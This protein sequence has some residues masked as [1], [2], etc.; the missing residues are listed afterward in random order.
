MKKELKLLLTNCLKAV[1]FFFLPFKDMM[2]LVKISIIILAVLFT[3]HTVPDMID[4]I[5]TYFYFRN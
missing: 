2:K 3:C 5:Q 1:E 4:F